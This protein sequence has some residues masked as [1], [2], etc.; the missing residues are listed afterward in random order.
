M[1]LIQTKGMAKL[2]RRKSVETKV[3]T[4]VFSKWSE[5]KQFVVVSWGRGEILVTWM[6]V[7]SVRREARNGG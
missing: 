2:C 7:K 3:G 4:A 6:S 5:K 1:R